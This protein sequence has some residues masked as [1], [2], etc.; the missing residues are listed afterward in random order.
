M[1]E[2]QELQLRR[3]SYIEECSALPVLRGF[4]RNVKQDSEASNASGGVSEANVSAWHSTVTK[5]IPMTS[6]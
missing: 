6:E 3:T 2:E 5:D 1:T 4:S